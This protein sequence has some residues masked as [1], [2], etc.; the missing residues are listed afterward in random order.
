MKG[1]NMILPRDIGTRLTFGSAST[2]ICKVI[3]PLLQQSKRI[4]QSTLRRQQRAAL[5][6]ELDLADPSTLNDRNRYSSGI[7]FASVG[8][9][10]QQTP[11]VESHPTFDDPLTD[12]VFGGQTVS[13]CAASRT[14]VQTWTSTTSMS[15]VSCP[16]LTQG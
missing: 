5:L 10:C 8:S 16:S 3:Q 1:H 6:T 13:D 7:F 15:S 14:E 2:T 12:F 4:N 11:G 9:K